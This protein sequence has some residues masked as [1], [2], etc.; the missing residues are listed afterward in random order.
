[1]ASCDVRKARRFFSPAL[2]V[3]ALALIAVPPLSGGCEAA[4]EIKLPFSL[5]W[6]DKP[7]AAD[8]HI[9]SAGCSKI[10]DNLYRGKLMEHNA[11]TELTF[12]NETGA[13]LKVH[14]TFD[15]NDVFGVLE[16]ALTKELGAPSPPADVP[17]LRS[18]NALQ[19]TLDS[20][21][22]YFPDQE[23]LVYLTNFRM[24]EYGWAELVYIN[25]GRS[26]SSIWPTIIMIII[27]TAFATASTILI[28]ALKS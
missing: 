9:T 16:E 24:S 20:P 21:T 2:A 6:N 17:E 25:I 26:K 18:L 23:K 8:R 28:R 4:A 27:V 14:V 5:G 13:L 22:W 3:L 15:T 1:M 19:K 11:K 10:R 12:K 7:A